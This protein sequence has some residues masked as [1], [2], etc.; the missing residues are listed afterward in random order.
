MLHRYGLGIKTPTPPDLLTRHHGPAQLLR[1]SQDARLYSLVFAGSGHVPAYSVAD[2][3]NL[4]PISS[5]KREC[6]LGYPL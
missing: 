3:L 2:F 1:I 4:N 6:F 5:R